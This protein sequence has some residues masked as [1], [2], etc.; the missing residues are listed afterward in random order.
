M[1]INKHLIAIALVAL[2]TTACGGGGGGG[3]S[4]NAGQTNTSQSPSENTTTSPQNNE[5]T[6]QVANE[7]TETETE[8]EVTA[9]S[10]MAVKGPLANAVA[11]LYS[12]NTSNAD[13]KGAL[14]AEGFTDIDAQLVMDV[15]NQYLS[16][17]FF[18]M[19]YTL[20]EEL[21]GSTPVIPT[22]RTLIS[23]EQLF[24]GTSVYATPLTTLAID[25]AIENLKGEAPPISVTDF[26]IAV[27]DAALQTIA[28]FG[29]G[30]IDSN[31]NIFTSSPVLSEATD[32]DESLAYRT[33]IEVFAALAEKVREES[34]ALGTTIDPEQLVQIFAEDMLDGS[35]DAQNN[36]EPISSLAALGTA[37]VQA[38]LSTDPNTLM[39]PGTETPIS[40]LLDTITTEAEQVAPE[41]V[42]TPIE[43][44][45][46]EGVELNPEVVE[47]P[48]GTDPQ[49]DPE[50]TIPDPSPSDPGSNPETPAE[51][52][53]EEPE[54][55]EPEPSTFDITIS[56]S[57][58]TTR[59]NGD[60]LTVAELAGYEIYYYLE[61][62]ENNGEVIEVTNAS[63]TSQ[64]LTLTTAGNYYFAIASIDTEGL[65]SEMSSPVSFLVE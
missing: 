7:T 2:L 23:S 40:E 34:E 5:N 27:N 10:S 14:V 46:P 18:I 15:E 47:P 30:I 44:P 61:G 28:A 8:T 4:D 54:V 56:W 33:T 22:L 65:E 58:P 63:A 62:D 37:G 3:G 49:V 20:G 11:S 45:D 13:Y 53:P 17:S 21:N 51:P 41:V 1:F 26:A 52:T 38:I 48:A 39:I 31:V 35:L 29:L 50:V 32:P 59:A 12:V 64:E 36:G 57:A 43:E 60:P 42:P 25:N 24:N 55:V 9:V 19:E 6:E 16:Q